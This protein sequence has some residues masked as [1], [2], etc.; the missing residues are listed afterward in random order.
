MCVKKRYAILYKEYISN[1]VI[2]FS[3]FYLFLYFDKVL[4]F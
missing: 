2:K 1:I 4:E 3:F